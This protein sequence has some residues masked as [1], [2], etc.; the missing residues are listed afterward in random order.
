MSL[1]LKHQTPEALLRRFRERFASSEKERCVEFGRALME[2]IAAGDL[3]EAQARAAFGYTVG[4]WN[5]LRTKMQRRI[6]A[7]VEINSAAGE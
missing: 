6:N 2:R 3:T 1:V 5:G 7:R 4:Q